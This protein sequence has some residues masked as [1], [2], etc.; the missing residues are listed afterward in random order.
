LLANL[1]VEL[2]LPVAPEPLLAAPAR[3]RWRVL[4]SSGDPRYGGFGAP[5]PESEAS[6]WVLG[7]H[8]AVVLAPGGAAGD[9]ERNPPGS[10]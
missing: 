5:A 10:V 8:S 9:E 7:G 6:N 3:K 1:G 2:R 4:W